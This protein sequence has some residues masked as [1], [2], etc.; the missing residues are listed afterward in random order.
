MKVLLCCAMRLWV[1]EGVNGVRDCPLA[2]VSKDDCYIG[3]A[4]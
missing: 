1:V 3:T 4:Q 2:G